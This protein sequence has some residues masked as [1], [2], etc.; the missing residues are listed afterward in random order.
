MCIL[1][2]KQLASY[3][4]IAILIVTHHHSYIIM[5]SATAMHLPDRLKLKEED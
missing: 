5:Y 2:F 1:I 4:Y 3:S